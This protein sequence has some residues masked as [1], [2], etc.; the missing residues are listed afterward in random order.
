MEIVEFK[1]GSSISTIETDGESQRSKVRHYSLTYDDIDLVNTIC[2]YC[3]SEQ[4]SAEEVITGFYNGRYTLRNE[5][6]IN[7][8]LIKNMIDDRECFMRDILNE[9]CFHYE[10]NVKHHI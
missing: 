4:L 7:M 1:N 2:K 3:N 8:E 10:S 5:K 6:Q 9:H